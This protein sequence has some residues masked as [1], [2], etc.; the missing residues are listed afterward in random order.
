MTLDELNVS[1]RYD[2]FKSFIRKQ[3]ASWPFTP[4]QFVWLHQEEDDHDEYYKL[5]GLSKHWCIEN[6]EGEFA[7]VATTII[8]G[9]QLASDAIKFKFA[10]SAW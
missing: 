5:R 9:F 8:V 3:V 6:C 10:S 7:I 2:Y 4:A 1:P